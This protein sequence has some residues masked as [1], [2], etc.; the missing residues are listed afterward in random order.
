VSCGGWLRTGI[1]GLSGWWLTLGMGRPVAS[2]RR[3]LPLGVA[4]VKGLIV[5]E[6]IYNSCFK[7]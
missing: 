5:G 3:C 1:L 7:V 4:G 6:D 2:C